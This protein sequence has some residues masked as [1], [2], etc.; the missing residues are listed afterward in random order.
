M[1]L[2]ED[3]LKP[4]RDSCSFN[5]LFWLDVFFDRFLLR[6]DFFFELMLLP[7]VPRS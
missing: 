2:S 4:S 6:E 7:K 1:S 5:E 3:L